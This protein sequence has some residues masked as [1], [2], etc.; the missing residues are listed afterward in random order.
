VNNGFILS[1]KL[2]NSILPKISSILKTLKKSDCDPKF[3]T[4]LWLSQTI[5]SHGFLKKHGGFQQIDTDEYASHG[6]LIKPLVIQYNSSKQKDQVMNPNAISLSNDNYYVST[7][8]CLR[9][10]NQQQK[11]LVDIYKNL[12]RGIKYVAILGFPDQ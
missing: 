11:V 8:P 2:L 9:E 12:L 7:N 4:A 10:I 5:Q 1:W 3:S 6:L